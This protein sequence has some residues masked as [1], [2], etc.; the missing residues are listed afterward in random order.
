MS[1]AAAQQGITWALEQP[2][3]VGGAPWSYEHGT[4]GHT[5]QGCMPPTCWWQR[6]EWGP[7]HSIGC[8]V[9]APSKGRAH[10][11]RQGTLVKP[12]QHWGHAGKGAAH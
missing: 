4:A 2:D 1:D 6:D 11:S 10:R 12:A 5:V 3:R 9:L 8:A 7:R